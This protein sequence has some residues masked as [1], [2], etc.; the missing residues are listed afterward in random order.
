MESEMTFDEAWKAATKGKKRQ[1]SAIYKKKKGIP[2]SPAPTATR[3]GV[4]QEIFEESMNQDNVNNPQHYKQYTLE[5]IEGIKG[6]MSNEEFQGYLK[7]AA[8]KYLWRYKNKQAPVEDL[9][10]AKWY[11]DKLLKEVLNERPT[12]SG[13]QS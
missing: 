12:I 6:S 1:K 8:L 5:A 13:P 11:L 3:R 9:R 4:S 2:P 10:K 7:G